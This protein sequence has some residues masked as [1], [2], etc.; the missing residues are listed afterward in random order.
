MIVRLFDYGRLDGAIDCVFSV[1]FSADADTARI[2]AFQ[3]G[4]ISGRHIFP[5]S[6]RLENAVWAISTASIP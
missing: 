4:I 1:F 6:V 2:Y 5:T 3:E